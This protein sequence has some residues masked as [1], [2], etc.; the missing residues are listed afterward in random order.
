MTPFDAFNCSKNSPIWFAYNKDA[1]ERLIAKAAPESFWYANSGKT[2]KRFEQG[3][4]V[5]TN[6]SNY[7]K[8]YYEKITQT[9]EITSFIY[10][11]I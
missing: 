11:F 10:K 6:D 3:E 4:Y 2:F 8:L 7:F 5:L 9:K 1:F